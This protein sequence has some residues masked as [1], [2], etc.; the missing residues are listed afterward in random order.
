MGRLLLANVHLWKRRHDTPSKAGIM[1][2]CCRSIIVFV[3]ISV[4]HQCSSNN[5]PPQPKCPKFKNFYKVDPIFLH[6]DFYHFVPS[7]RGFS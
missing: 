3:L 4:M 1:K 6:Q 2:T 5:I 7:L